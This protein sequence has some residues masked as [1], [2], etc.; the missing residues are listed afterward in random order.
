[1]QKL[2]TLKI[3]PKAQYEDIKQGFMINDTFVFQQETV[4]NSKY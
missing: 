1:M 4:F 3:F 2:A